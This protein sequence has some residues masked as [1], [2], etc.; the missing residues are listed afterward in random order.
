[1]FFKKSPHAKKTNKQT[2]EEGKRKS[3]RGRRQTDLGINLASKIKLA[4][5]CTILLCLC[6]VLIEPFKEDFVHKNTL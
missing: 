1:M 5:R 6:T 3:L 2:K 4:V